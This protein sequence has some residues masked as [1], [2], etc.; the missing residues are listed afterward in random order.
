MEIIWKGNRYNVKIDKRKKNS[1]L[2]LINRNPE[3]IPIEFHTH[4]VWTGKHWDDK[5]SNGD[6]EIIGKMLSINP[7]YMHVLFTPQNI[8]TVA[9]SKM[10]FNLG[11]TNTE[12]G[13]KIIERFKEI[14]NEYESILRNI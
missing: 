14:K 12:I 6:Y 4:T 7:E 1:I 10:A 11:D 2:E 3:L 13:N 9:K 8:L 5:F